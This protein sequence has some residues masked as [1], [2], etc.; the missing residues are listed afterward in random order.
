MIDLVFGKLLYLLWHFYATGLIVIVVNGQRLNNNKVIWSHC[1]R[2]IPPAFNH[3]S[4]GLAD[5]LRSERD[6]IE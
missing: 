2:P 4:C 3:E 5:R 1:S 6:G